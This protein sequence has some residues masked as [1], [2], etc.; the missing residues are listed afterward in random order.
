V[1]TRL[2][3][4]TIGVAVLL[5][6][7]HLTAAAGVLDATAAPRLLA[8]TGM[9]AC[10]AAAWGP[11]RS[12]VY[13]GIGAGVYGVADVAAKLIGA[14]VAPDLTVLSLAPAAALM[15]LVTQRMIDERNAVVG[16]R[17]AADRLLAD[18]AREP[19]APDDIRLVAA[20]VDP[21]VLSPGGLLGAIRTAA[22]D[23]R[24]GTRWTA[25]AASSFMVLGGIGTGIEFLV[26]AGLGGF[27]GCA[28]SWVYGSLAGGLSPLDSL[29]AGYF[30]LAVDGF[31]AAMRRE[32]QDPL[33]RL[34]LSASLHSVGRHEQ[35][36]KE[37]SVA[38][39]GVIWRFTPVAVR[40]AAEGLAARE[41]MAAG[42][43]S[44]AAQVLSR[45][46]TVF[47]R[48]PAVLRDLA[49]CYEGLGNG[50]RARRLLE[51]AAALGSEPALLRLAESATAE[52]AAEP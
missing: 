47:P 51:D 23:R 6:A 15:G 36:L 14:K 1:N 18:A 35:A 45:L 28:I 19:G 31:A 17:R 29:A 37:L 12:W 9:Y 22:R 24:R 2:L 38:Q 52:E 26:F 4:V 21:M 33:L 3:I 46:Q 50:W 27:V 32:P 16:L 39:Q 5:A 48:C 43:H 10:A 42:R 40:F 8:V 13:A 11:P 34:G 30:G 49:E 20:Q 7:D 44:Q 41:L 25:L